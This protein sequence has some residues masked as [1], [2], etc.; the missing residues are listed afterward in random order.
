MYL[1]FH[2]FLT[3]YLQQQHV[4]FVLGGSEGLLDLCGRGGGVIRSE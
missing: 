2:F 1:C 4:V 3:V